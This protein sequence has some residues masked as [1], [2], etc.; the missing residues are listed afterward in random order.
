MKLFKKEKRSKLPVIGLILAFVPVFSFILMSLYDSYIPYWIYKGI[1]KNITVL[2][3]VLVLI[4]I[5][6]T[7][8][9]IKG[10]KDKLD[11]LLSFVS[12][13]INGI[14]ITFNSLLIYLI[15]ASGVNFNNYSFIYKLSAVIN[16]ST[17]LIT[18]FLALLFLVIGGYRIFKSK[19]K[20]SGIILYILGVVLACLA[21]VGFNFVLL[22]L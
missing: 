10:L 22:F 20:E 15:N 1:D 7:L 18:A 13:T 17:S 2:L 16:K 3:I 6:S 8:F 19:K 9:S 12:I 4:A 5:L 21:F 14:T 11:K